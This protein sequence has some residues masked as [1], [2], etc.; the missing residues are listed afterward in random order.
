M[1]RKQGFRRH[2]NPDGSQGGWVDVRAKVD[3]TVYI[4]PTAEVYDKSRIRGNVRLL[5]HAKVFNAVVKDNVTLRDS[6]QALYCLLQGNV[7]L[8]GNA[9]A[10]GTRAIWSG[11][12][13][14]SDLMIEGDTHIHD[15]TVENIRHHPAL[16]ISGGEFLCPP[17][18]KIPEGCDATLTFEGGYDRETGKVIV[19]RVGVQADASEPVTP[20]ANEAELVGYIQKSLLPGRTIDRIEFR[21]PVTLP[22]NLCRP[23]TD[24]RKR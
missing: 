22:S 8:S 23:A 13:E 16:I 10:S 12:E 4:A 17:D 21:N 7:E 5:D 9:C 15:I 1:E 18:L 19:D 6:A 2:K 11:A 24:T 20:L 3:P 14:S